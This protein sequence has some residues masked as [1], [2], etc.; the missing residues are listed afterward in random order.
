MNRLV[1]CLTVLVLLVAMPAWAYDGIVEKKTFA[2]PAYA[3]VGGTTIKGVRVGYE[4]YGT[5]NAARDNV[6]LVAH[7]YSSNSHAAG[8]Y[9]ASD[10]A[11]GYWDAIIGSGKPI[12]TD[13]FFVVSS[14]TLVNLNVKDPNTITTGP[15]SIDPD[16]GKAYGMT[17][18]IVTIR[19]FVNV[20]KALLDSL[21]ITRL[22]AVTGASMGAL[23]ALEWAA[24]YPDMVE[25]AIPVLPAGE[26]P[27]FTIG[28]A[29]IWAAPIRLDPRWNGGDY[30]GRPEPV[31]G[32]AEALKIVTLHARHYGW[33]T[34]TFGR[35][36]AAPDRDPAV[37][38][39]LGP[40]GGFRA[41]I[42]PGFW[43]GPDRARRPPEPKT[44]R[45][46]APGGLPSLRL[47]SL[48]RGGGRGRGRAREA[49]PH[50][51]REWLPVLQD[52]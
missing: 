39:R 28:W 23:Q 33:A 25:R 14:D 6:V 15:A 10:P 13:R 45:S 26:L 32:L 52:V 4:T 7:F 12:D 11:P 8:K 9:A 40:A 27:A 2:M 41:T 17:F 24:A 48:D 30:Y 37:P 34:R 42:R 51:G 50:A 5:L 19:D 31:D 1:G 46:A 47:V 43:H 20:Q 29:N 49:H 16:T 38:R 22:R 21:G 35:K 36:W 18:P 44:G 3:T